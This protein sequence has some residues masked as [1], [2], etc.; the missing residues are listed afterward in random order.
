MLKDF[1]E[2][3]AKGNVI[4][5]AVGVMIGAAFGAII[6]SFVKDLLTPLIGI[7]GKANFENMFVVLHAGD[8]DPGP[9]ASLDAAQKAGANVLSYGVFLN[10]FINFL[11][12]AFTLFLIVRGVNKMK[13]KEAEAA[14]AAPPE[15]TAEEKLL[16]EIRDLLKK[17]PA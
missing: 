17:S 1:R 14:P 5:L 4:D 6:G 10:A 11:I 7:A 3:I 13:R 16:T 15:P 2:F 12:I 8:K 9:Y